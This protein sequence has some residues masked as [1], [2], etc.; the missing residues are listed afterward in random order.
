MK[1]RLVAIDL[2]GT[3]LNSAKEI[4]ATTATI[5][6]TAREVAGVRVVLATARPPRTVLPFYSLLG[7]D[8]PMINYNGALVHEPH[9]GRIILHRP[10]EAKLARIIAAMARKM[11]PEVLVSAEVL[12]KWYTDRVEDTWRSETPSLTR[13]DM[14]APMGKWLN[15]P[16]T[17]LLLL[18]KRKWLTDIHKAVQTRMPAQTAMARSEDC[19]LQ[20]MHP[21]VGKGAALRTV[22]AEME[23]TSEQVMAIGD[24]ANDAGMLQWA[25]I[26][27]AMGNASAHARRVANYVTADHDA[28]GAAKA[29]A[30]LI[31]GPATKNN[32]KP[33]A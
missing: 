2:D 21:S 32:D 29:I 31:V 9:T 7:L 6:R 25:G 27:V 15:Q 11:F 26:G 30:K 10:M 24:N 23:L 13:P 16:I 33:H 4:T 19:M 22:A 17:K 12:D 18:G 5:I 3:L 8:T 20:I 1:I 28:D 14:V